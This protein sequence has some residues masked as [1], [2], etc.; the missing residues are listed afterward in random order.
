VTPREQRLAYAAWAAV[1]FFWGTT[2][3]AIRIG[4]ESLPPALFAGLRFLAAGV[5][6]A[7]VLRLRGERLPAGRDLVRLALIGIVLL[8][9]GNTAVVWASRW[10]PSGVVSL[11]IAMTPFWMTGM[12]SLRPGGE[13]FTTRVTLGLLFGLGGLAL[14]MSPRMHGTGWHPNTLL[15]VLAL[16]AGCASWSAGSLYSRAHPVDVP[17]LMGAAIQMIAAGAALSLLG[18]C[19]GEWPHFVFSAR[20]LAAF[21]YLLV[22]GSLVAYSAYTYALQKLPISTVSL[23]SYINPVIAVVLGAMVLHEPLTWREITAVIVI[24]GG[25]AI[26]KSAGLPLP[27]RARA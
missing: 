8:G 17:P 16:Q 24:L 12:D 21:L 5:I 14:L 27:G 9:T 20:S 10:L 3:L 13:R 26:V 11:V 15:S 2:Y 1:C 6:L 18:T 25:V 19:L 7:A 23:Y 4:V 22:F